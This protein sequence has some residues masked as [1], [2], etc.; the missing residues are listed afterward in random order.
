MKQDFINL[1]K[2]STNKHII[3]MKKFAKEHKVPIITDE[4]LIFLCQLA[5]LL[6][7]VAILELGTAIGFSSVHLALEN[8]NAK[9]DTIERN[10]EMVNEA[11]KNIA[12]LKLSN[13]IRVI[14]AD[15]ETLPLSAL[16]ESYDLIFIDAAKAQYIK[17][18]EKYQ[19]LLSKKGIIVSDNLLFH[20]LVETKEKIESKN[21]RNLVDKIKKYNIYLANHKNFS[22]SFFA[23]GDGMAVTERKM[24]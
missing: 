14:E 7:P 23:I 2:T 21:V 15:I 17:F 12:A 9:I 13:Q 18:F 5:R 8:P 3:S 4:G 16:Q 20:G 22:T 11:K 1:N 6:E 24:K 19:V 10:P